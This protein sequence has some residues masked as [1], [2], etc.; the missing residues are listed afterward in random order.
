MNCCGNC[1]HYKEGTFNRQT[2]H[3]CDRDFGVT[4]F[5]VVACDDWEPI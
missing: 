1:K 2:E 5:V 4:W 3:Y